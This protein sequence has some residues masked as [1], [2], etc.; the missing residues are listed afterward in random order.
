MSATLLH[1]AESVAGLFPP[2][3]VEAERVAQAVWQGVHGRRRPGIGE[4]FWQF[5]PYTPTDPAARIDWRQSARGDRL[6]VREREWEAAQGVYLWAD[7]SGSMRYASSS[8]VPTKSERAQLLMLALASLLLRGGER[9]TWLDHRRSTAVHGRGGLE[10]IAAR[11]APDAEP[12]DASLPPAVPLA[13]YAHMVLCSDFLTAPEDLQKQMHLYAVQNLRGAFVHVIDPAEESFALSGR[14]EL[15]GCENE[16]PLRLSNAAALRET[17]LKKMQEHEA[18]LRL[19]AESAGWFYVRHIT[20]TQPH[21][22]L[23]QLYEGLA[24]GARP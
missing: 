22:A 6:Y 13:R 5:R 21:Q 11:I 24:A 14:L 10:R 2:L 19:M 12:S 1:R 7:A 17:Y 23:L 18:R 16:A 3:L 15:Q 9:V 20:S 4:S 8:K